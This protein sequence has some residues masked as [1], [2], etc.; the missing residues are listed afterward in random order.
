M[1]LYTYDNNGFEGANLSISE[2]FH[3]GFSGGQPQLDQVLLEGCV[4]VHGVCL[5][6]FCLQV[7]ICG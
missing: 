5:L 4:H 6:T 1:T 7:S 2:Y 3:V